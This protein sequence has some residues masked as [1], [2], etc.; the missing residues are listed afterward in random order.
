[1]KSFF[2]WTVRHTWAVR[3]CLC[4]MLCN[5]DILQTAENQ[6]Q[7]NSFDELSAF[8][9]T[10]MQNFKLV[11]NAR[12]AGVFIRRAIYVQPM[13]RWQQIAMR[14][15]SLMATNEHLNCW[16]IN[17]HRSCSWKNKGV[18]SKSIVC[19]NKHLNFI[20]KPLLLVAIHS[21]PFADSIRSMSVEEISRYFINGGMM[22]HLSHFK[23]HS[24]L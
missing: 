24:F 12:F 13:Q 21:S 20:S 23:G 11:I 16:M 9:T 22:W 18:M 2:R 19:I 1:M 5:N 14:C 10:F 7:H 17:T 4:F 15:G 3:S 8:S 6:R